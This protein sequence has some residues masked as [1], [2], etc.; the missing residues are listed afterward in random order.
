MATEGPEDTGTPAATAATDTSANRS[1]RAGLATTKLNREVVARRLRCRH[2]PGDDF[3]RSRVEHW[4][5]FWQSLTW[6]H[7]SNLPISS[8]PNRQVGNLPPH[9]VTP[10]HVLPQ[11]EREISFAGVSHNPLAPEHPSPSNAAPCRLVHDEPQ[12]EEPLQG[13]G[14][15]SSFNS[16]SILS[17]MAW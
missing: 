1:A 3:A 15:Y 6:R 17:C 7:V 5:V 11:S 14:F 9:S 13:M 4:P 16:P 8:R 12:C 2:R 10:S